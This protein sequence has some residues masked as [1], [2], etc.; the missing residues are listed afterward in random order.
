M[1]VAIVGYGVEGRASATYFAARGHTVTICDEQVN[2]EV[3]ENFQAQLGDGY[4]INLDRFDVIVRSAGIHPQ[5][6]L[7]EN[8]GVATKITTA[9]NE[10]LVHS[11]TRN[12]IGVTGTKGKGTTSTLIANILEAAGRKTWLGGNIGRS[13]LEFMDQLTEDDWVVLELSSFQ[14]YDLHRS[15]HIAVCLMV[16]PEHLNWH[17]GVEDYHAAKSHLFEY[18][19]SDDVAIYYVDNA[20][21]SQIASA[22]AGQK[23]PFYRSPGAW[24]NES[25][26]IEID[27]RAICSTSDLKLLG[28]HNWQNVCAAV[29]A[30]WQSGCHDTS[31]I[32]T[33]ITSFT[34]LPHRLEFVR[35]VNGVRYYND[36][37][38]ATP[39]AAIAALDAIPGDKVIVVGGFDRGLP[40]EHLAH[41]LKEHQ[42]D[43]TALL[44]GQS[45]TRLKSVCD[46]I[47]ATNMIIHP[48]RTMQEIVTEATRLADKHGSVV[49]SP[50]FAS[51]DMFKNF[52]DR[53]NQFM[54][55]V[56][57][58]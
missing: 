3:A 1:N 28:K 8:P 9:I 16:V 55:V 45:A 10:F 47:N 41:A 13:P 33:A 22:G 25:S 37:F 7:E 26:E 42:T 31:A 24:I 49:L 43:T 6:I 44:V 27:G 53:G 30:T 58:L 20:T 12:I 52:E 32:R 40:L 29:T 54:K 11:P 39:D 18:Q 56:A 57:S 19:N 5:V 46:T 36:S 34:G 23:I 17:N 35:E 51:F 15:P 4:L 48:A 2:T 50:G 21:S 38:A 14:L